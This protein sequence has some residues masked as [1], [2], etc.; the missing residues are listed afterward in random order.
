M[1]ITELE[2]AIELNHKHGLGENLSGRLSS[3]SIKSE[4]INEKADDNGN[5]HCWSG[6]RK[7]GLKKKGGKM[8]NDCRPIKK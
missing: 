4:G 3:L 5:T 7:A 8:V 6:Y 1:K 2:K